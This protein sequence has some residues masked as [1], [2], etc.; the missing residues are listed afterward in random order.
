MRSAICSSLIPPERDLLLD[1]MADDLK[2]NL[3]RV[4]E[5]REGENV[6][7]YVSQR[8]TKRVENARGGGMRAAVFKGKRKERQVMDREM[9]RKPSRMRCCIC[10]R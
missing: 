1:M 8:M 7:M 3:R 5:Q 2:L 10:W 9:L 6:Y 4:R